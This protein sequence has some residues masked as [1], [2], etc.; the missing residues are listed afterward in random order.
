MLFVNVATESCKSVIAT[1]SSGACEQWIALAE[2]SD[3]PIIHGLFVRTPKKN[4]ILW[5]SG[6]A[7]SSLSG[8]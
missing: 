8:R 6:I 4:D 3:V 7:E 5:L 1:A 2:C